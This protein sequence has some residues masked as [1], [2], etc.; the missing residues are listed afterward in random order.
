MKTPTAINRSQPG[1][2]ALAAMLEAAGIDRSLEQVKDIAAGFAASA[3]PARVDGGR[4]LEL[5]APGADDELTAALEAMVNEFADSFVPA[6]PAPSTAGERLSALRDELARRTLDGFLV[7]RGD[8]HQGEYVAAR[9]QRLAWLTGFT[10]SAGLAV[11]LVE[12]GA[13]FVDGRYTLQVRDQVDGEL[14]APH[15]LT[16]SPPQ[17]WI[18]ANLGAN[19]RLGYDPWLHT[20]GEIER[21]R[22]ACEKSGA[23][24]VACESNPID[25]VWTNQPPPPLG[26]VVPHDLF[27]AGESA[28]DKRHRI[29]ADLADEGIDAVVLTMPDSI[30]WLLNIRGAD[31]PNTPLPL[32]FAVLHNSGN[33]DLFIDGRKLASDLP[34]H[35][36]NQVA[37]HAP[38][39]LTET[40]AMF[41]DGKTIQVD[42]AS[43]AAWVFDRLD[44]AGARV[45]RGPDPCAA[46]KS[47]KNE[48]E[49]RGI[50]AAHVR[51]GA[52]L[53]RFLS[54]LAAEAPKGQIDELAAAARLAA[55]RAE[56]EHFR[57]LS[58]DAITGAGPNGAIVHYMSTAAT[59]RRLEPGTLFLVDSGGQYL[60]G[61]TD[62]TRTVAIGTPDAEH[63]DR[64]T[65]VL[66][67]HITLAT[68]RFPEGTSG[69]QLDALA[70]VH[71]WRAGLDYDHGTGHGVGSYLSV[72]EGPQR[73][74]KI[75][76]RVALKPGMIVSNEPGYYKTEAYGIRIENLVAVTELREPED[77]E[78]KFLA[79]E[80]LTK[81]PIDLDLIEP[82]LLTDEEIDWLNAYHADV[83]DTL[84]PLVDA[85]TAAWLAS[86][87]RAVTR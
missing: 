85:E 51:D 62:V 9:A 54:W 70:R 14:F 81:A 29:A 87:T 4:W 66:K 27:F 32:S 75:P 67:G 12:C 13:I 11:A 63:R 20:E 47:C 18:A 24:L 10:G 1:D 60:D 50:R 46:L 53:T 43:A 21:Y 48:T 15:H 19:A 74:S 45:V 83:R 25:A 8:E 77:G 59:S 68:C 6:P 7:P 80:T 28:S 16:D 5:L 79:F 31:V 36:G 71:L 61:T 22:K 26:P 78:K 69:S 73:I 65:R 57:G 84:T 86:A 55:L 52:A 34:S 76:N 3:A 72:H 82:A 39:R 56:N 40:L 33:V 23:M 17:D 38:A 44:D 30:A 42:P 64:F 2:D 35:L 58:F 41:G 49:L 37:V